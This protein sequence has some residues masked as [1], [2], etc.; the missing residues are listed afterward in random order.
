MRAKLI[1]VLG[2]ALGV[3]VVWQASSVVHTQAP[4]CLLTTAQG[5]VL[6]VHR[7]AS[8]AFL[9]VPFGAPPTGDLRWRPPVAAPDW[10]PSRLDAT[11][12]PPA[13]GT[14]PQGREDCLKLN[15]W[16]PSP[17][18]GAAVPVIVWLHPGSFFAASANLAAQNGER[19]AEETGTII[20]APNYRLGPFGFLAHEALRNDDPSYPTA[21]NY[22]LLD[23][24]LALEWVREHIADFGGDP[25]RITVAGQSAGALS[26]SLHL[27]APGSWGLFDRAILQG[28]AASYRWRTRVDGASQGEAFA[29]Q[30]GC[31][32]PA[33]VV[34]CLRSKT[35]TEILAALPTGTEQFAEDSRTHWS[36][37]VDGF[38]IP[39]QPRMLFEAG[40]FSQVPVLLGSN[41]DEGWTF[42]NRSFPDTPTGPYEMTVEEYES[43]VSTEFGADA[44]AILAAYPPAD[45]RGN[46]KEALSK[47]VDD[48]E[49]ACGASRLARLIERHQVPVYLYSFHYSIAGLILGRAFHGIDVNLVFGNNFGPP[50][51]PHVLTPD[52]ENIF[53]KVSGYWTRFA[54]RGNPNIDDV[55]VAHWPRFKHPTGRGEGAD[56]YLLIDSTFQEGK[57]LREAQCA[58]WEPYFFRSIT[59][60]VPAHTP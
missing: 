43:A 20:V 31:T 24:R 29:A 1:A 21:G 33:E 10:T 37:V 13:C 53:I 48:A 11:L 56:K 49:Y 41:R 59:A 32:D 16:A 23:Q 2:T 46:P 44:P 28:G 38:V 40:A 4:T 26:V 8:C 7:G 52:D 50:S 55:N 5:D 12:P 14:G 58:F 19:L 36:P 18:A 42:V 57:R 3:M 17:A 35:R 60:A 39:D 34:T 47:L 6:G 54:E 15:I 25:T 22:G 27:V 9:G 45:Y 51:P 30:L